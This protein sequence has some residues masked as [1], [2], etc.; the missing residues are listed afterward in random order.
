VNNGYGKISP[1][2]V[3]L[4]RRWWSGICTSRSFSA[5][6]PRH[7]R[8]PERRRWMAGCA[9]IAAASVA[10]VSTRTVSSSAL[11]GP[12]GARRN[13]GRP[14]GSRAV[15]GWST[16]RNDR[17]PS[18]RLCWRTPHE[19]PLEVR[20]K[21]LTHAGVAA[22]GQAAPPPLGPATSKCSK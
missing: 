15:Q 5:P 6:S 10:S 14:G 18:I 4:Q 2:A 8:M 21:G 16:A 20:Q 19:R 17:W 9:T 7:R 1:E 3:G 12:Q 13:P 11:S 22:D